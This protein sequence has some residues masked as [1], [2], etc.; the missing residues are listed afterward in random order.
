MPGC[1]FRV[2]F[3]CALSCTQVLAKWIECRLMQKRLIQAQYLIKKICTISWVVF[4][5][6]LTKNAQD[7]RNIKNTLDTLYRCVVVVAAQRS[8][9][10]NKITPYC[11]GCVG[12]H[13]EYSERWLLGMNTQCTFISLYLNILLNLSVLTAINCNVSLSKLVSNESAFIK[14]SSYMLGLCWAL[15]PFS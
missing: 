3:P 13:S 11:I 5:N 15:M 4:S 8:S 2:H 9:T 12:W 10:V 7:I 1:T 6:V 14:L